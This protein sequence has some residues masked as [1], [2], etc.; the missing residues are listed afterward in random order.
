[1]ENDKNLNQ[2]MRIKLK[3]LDENNTIK[4]DVND[5]SARASYM[6][7]G[8]ESEVHRVLKTLNPNNNKLG[9]S[10]Y[11]FISDLLV[12]KIND[13]NAFSNLDGNITV[14]DI[15]YKF[16]L[17]SAGNTRDGKSIYVNKQY[18]DMAHEILLC[19]IDKEVE[20]DVMAKY[21]SYY[22]LASSDSIPIKEGLN[23][24]VI[25]DYEHEITEYFDIVEETSPDEYIVTPNQEKTIKT[26]PFDGCGL[27]E[28]EAAK[29]I[30]NQ[31]GLKYLPSAFQLR[32]IPGGK[33]NVITTDIRA[34]AAKNNKRKI[35]D[36][37]GKEW[38]LWNDNIEAIL[39]LSMFK[40][41]KQWA[42]FDYWVKSFQEETYGY[43]RTINVCKVADFAPKS[44]MPLS[45]Q[46][47]QSL[48]I[49]EDDIKELCKKTV[50]IV[51]G[52]SSNV[53]EFLKYRGISS[54]FDENGKQAEVEV[55]DYY[56]ALSIEKSLFND[57][58][59]HSKVKKDI[60]GIKNRAYRGG[61]F[62]EAGYQTFMPDIKGLLQ[63]CFGMEVIGCIP[64]N[65]IYSYYWLNKNVKEICSVRF[66]HISMEWVLSEV[67]DVPNEDTYIFKY[68]KEGVCCS[69]DDSMALRLGGAD[70]DN[71]KI[72][73]IN[74]KLLYSLAE[75][76][77][78]NTI[79][80]IPYE[81][82]EKEKEQYIKANRR[83]I[84]DEAYIRQTIINGKKNSI[85]KVVNNITKL[86][87]L[88]NDD[89]R[90]ESL[91]KEE[92]IKI[93]SVVGSK[94]IDF[95]KTGIPAAT[96]K[97]IMD[98]L[99]GVDK[100]EFMAF[101]YKKLKLKEERNNRLNQIMGKQNEFFFDGQDCTMQRLSK[102]LQ[103]QIGKENVSLER[104]VF[105][106]KVLLGNSERDFYTDNCKNVVNK[107]IELKSESDELAQKYVFDS[108]ND[109]SDDTKS[110]NKE[111]YR[112]FYSYCKTELLSIENNIESLVDYVIYAFY[113]NRKSKCEDK[114]IMWNVFGKEIIRRLRFNK[115]L[116][117][118][119][120]EKIDKLQE[121]RSK[122]KE[123]VKKQKEKSKVV[124]INWKVITYAKDENKECTEN[125]VP[126]EM[127]VFDGVIN[128]SK[129]EIKSIKDLREAKLKPLLFTLLALQK[130]CQKANVPLE[131]HQ[132]KK[133]KLVE[134]HIL[135]LSGVSQRNYTE[136]MN[137]LFKKGLIKIIKIGAKSGGMFVN[138][139]INSD[140]A[141]NEI[142]I[143]NIDE[144]RKYI[145]KIA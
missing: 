127:P 41:G 90:F 73:N 82:P 58:W 87:M 119:P 72:M 84:T 4:F 83:K 120:Q 126:K 100:P 24:I 16:L 17:S 98:I 31:L 49:C 93:M 107:L 77:M 18:Y 27:I 145:K 101:K 138:V 55:P 136:M 91:S 140:N 67:V 38:D 116:K 129:S 43:K 23:F 75:K 99:T 141:D 76:Q 34:F 81:M 3:E 12:I 47:I 63:Y 36:Y 144:I 61:I 51:K 132:G 123:K 85:G 32:F 48:N 5:K 137:Q 66:P 112:I 109:Y 20:F 68:I 74:S 88:P 80:P 33:G 121:K 97:S 11:P 28:I 134:S 9:I 56:K 86:W 6:T 124:K 65:K 92:T 26:K 30:Q 57:S 122:L 103:S 10:G 50:D 21:L 52:I 143:N 44:E 39:T 35:R 7:L 37:R 8:R 105:D 45:Y 62:A 29:R 108:Q 22:A 94:T 71:D 139:N 113:S 53:D 19:G 125:A 15:E 25:N 64:K 111:K 14:N 40:F 142:T 133:S 135:R 89:E 95:A 2:I 128:L 131:I 60:E 54:L 130:Y 114:S 46:P 42:E 79:L 70:F 78:T 102:Y 13:D 59:I 115:P 69:L 117:Q 118:L 96:P 106:W 104:N 110:C 1:M